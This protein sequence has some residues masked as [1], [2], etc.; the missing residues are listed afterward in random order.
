M[1]DLLEEKQSPQG[2]GNR[3]GERQHD[4]SEVGVEAGIAGW[5]VLPLSW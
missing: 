5:A 1:S 3:G 4:Q 2:A